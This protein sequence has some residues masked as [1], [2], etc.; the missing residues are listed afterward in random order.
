MHFIELISG[1]LLFHK[2]ISIEL[3]SH[4]FQLYQTILVTHFVL[5]YYSCSHVVLGV[6]VR[7]VE[8][9]F[10]KDLHILQVRH[11]I[12]IFLF[13]EVD[14]DDFLF[15]FCEQDEVDG[16]IDAQEDSGTDTDEEVLSPLEFLMS[17][18]IDEVE[19]PTLVL[20]LFYWSTLVAIFDLDLQ[21]IF[22]IH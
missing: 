4:Q 3:T 13:K 17:D 16:E 12:G 2:G 8:Q 1:Y 9:H 14:C 5:V 19:I 21:I 18:F 6:H 11:Y 20:V 10:F 22:F 15:D 7:Q